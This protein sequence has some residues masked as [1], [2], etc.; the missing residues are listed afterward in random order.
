MDVS[1][2]SDN[3]EIREYCLDLFNISAVIADIREVN[4][5][6][7][8][9]FVEKNINLCFNKLQINQKYLFKGNRIR[10]RFFQF[11]PNV[12]QSSGNIYL[13]GYW[14]SYK[15]FDDV[16][17]KIEQEFSLKNK[18]LECSNELY[19]DILTSNAV[20]LNFRRTDFV[21][22][23]LHSSLIGEYGNYY[24]KKSIKFIADSIENPKF[25]V[26]SD[27]INWCKHNVQIDAPVIF[28][29]HNHSG[30]KFYNYFKL[31]L[32]CKHFIIPNSTFGWWAAWLSQNSNKIV[33]APKIWFTD[34]TIDTSDLIPDTWFRF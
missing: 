7:K 3:Y 18:L 24:Y 12:L 22:T 20:C 28:V 15:Y 33:V 32:A 11:D 21:T 25:F 8:L 6:S 4:K 34:D 29:D 27:D 26:F 16:K 14:Q 30:L 9:N 19:N 5:I 17:R 23:N 1:K 13:D 31:M 10:E 2:Y